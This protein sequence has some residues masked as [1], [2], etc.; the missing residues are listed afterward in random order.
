MAKRSSD[1]WLLV[2]PTK[3]DEDELISCVSC[4]D[5]SIGCNLIKIYSS[6]LN[7][8]KSEP[9]SLLNATRISLQLTSIQ[10]QDNV[11]PFRNLFSTADLF[12]N[13]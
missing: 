7:R 9:L 6:L 8:S 11:S 13:T 10:K 2:T 12:G 3:D 4:D 5:Q 1:V